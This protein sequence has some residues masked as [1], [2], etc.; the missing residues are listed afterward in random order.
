[1]QSKDTIFVVKVLTI[2]GKII[3]IKS[4]FLPIFT[5]LFIAI[6]NPDNIFFKQF[7]TLL[8]K[9]IWNDK[10]DKI[11]INLLSINMEDLKV[12]EGRKCFI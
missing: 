5:H 6:P 11:K 8:Y 1:M 2:N 12:R 4:K 3:I 10:R 9:F 7:N